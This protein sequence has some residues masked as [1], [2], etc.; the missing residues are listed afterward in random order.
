MEVEYKWV[1]ILDKAHSHLQPPSD[2]AKPLPVHLQHKNCATE[3]PANEVPKVDDP[4]FD[5]SSPQVIAEFVTYKPTALAA[6]KVD[7]MKEKQLW[8]YL[9]KMSTDAKQYYTG[10]PSR[11]IHDPLSNFLDSVKPPP[12]IGQPEGRKQIPT[13]HPNTYARN[14]LEKPAQTLPHS[15]TKSTTSGIETDLIKALQQ[16]KNRGIFI[17]SG[18]SVQNLTPSRNP[19]ISGSN[20][21][22]SSTTANSASSASS[23][24]SGNLG[25]RPP[26]NKS[27]QPASS[28]A[29]ATTKLDAKAITQTGSPFKTSTLPQLAPYQIPRPSTTPVSNPTPQQQQIFRFKEQ[30]GYRVPTSTKTSS[31][32]P[33]TI[34]T[35]SQD[36]LQAT[37]AATTTTTTNMMI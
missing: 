6:P 15:Q 31:P 9:G 28:T 25:G 10:D 24:Q 35:A 33:S 17:G 5:S 4:F 34:P 16:E 29:T 22:T 1:L 26:D 21:G 30:Q 23:I 18:A 13:S 20:A 12:Y 36:Q 11:E 27:S 19:W 7:L 37:T 32:K 3:D 14:N 8:Y 2:T